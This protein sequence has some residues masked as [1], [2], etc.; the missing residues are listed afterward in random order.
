MDA[1]RARR[2]RGSLSRWTTRT[3]TL[4]RNLVLRR[5]SRVEAGPAQLSRARAQLRCGLLSRE[6]LVW[7]EGMGT[8]RPAREFPVFASCCS[9]ERVGYDPRLPRGGGGGVGDRDAR[10]APPP[11]LAPSAFASAGDPHLTTRARTGP[12]RALPAPPPDLTLYPPAAPRVVRRRRGGSRE[13]PMSTAELLDLLNTDGES[14][15]RRGCG[16][17]PRSPKIPRGTCAELSSALRAVGR[18]DDA[19]ATLPGA[20]PSPAL[21]AALPP[22]A[23]AARPSRGGKRR[24]RAARL[25][26]PVPVPVPSRPVPDIIPERVP[27]AFPPSNDPAGARP[28]AAPR[29]RAPGE[30]PARFRPGLPGPG[31]GRRARD[32]DARRGDHRRAHRTPRATARNS[33]ARTR[34]TRR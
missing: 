16:A 30:I 22:A 23:T 27:N 31:G 29:P 11:S 33:R 26:I 21:H 10:A 15:S 17:K 18:T 8:W 5:P 25:P 1:T 3:V 12:A 13:G 24:R 6:T 9:G 7:R 14:A 34:R 2:R 4:R 19:R 28:A 32:G 20:P